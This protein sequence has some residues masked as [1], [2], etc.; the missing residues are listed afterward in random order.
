[1]TE[2]YIFVGMARDKKLYMAESKSI[3]DGYVAF[4]LRDKSNEPIGKVFQD[5]IWIEQE[6]LCS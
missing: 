3:L 4:V 2:Q 6:V 5:H 1:M